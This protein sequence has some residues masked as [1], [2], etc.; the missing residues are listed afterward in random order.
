MRS[1]ES[2]VVTVGERTERQNMAFVVVEKGNGGDIGKVFSPR[3][4]R[5][6]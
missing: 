1:L 5:I 3:R 4:G 2:L 6:I